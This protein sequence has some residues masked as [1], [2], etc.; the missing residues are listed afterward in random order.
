MDQSI[1]QSLVKWPNV[2]HCFGWLALDRRG[3]WRM[4]DDYAQVHGLSGDVIKHAAL[5][6]FIARNYASDAEGRYFFQN[7]PQRV[8]INLDATPWVIRMMPTGNAEH[9]WQFQTQCDS[10]LLPTAAFMDEAGHILIEG[11]LTQTICTVAT[12][13]QFSEIERLSI[14][15]L[16]DHDIELFSGLASLSN[17]VC[18]LEGIWRWHDHDLKLEPIA[19]TELESRFQFQTRPQP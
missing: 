14:A 8:Y 6:A 19:T 16:H 7:G 10:L 5:N 17:T 13:N 9:P 18:A 1:A 4:R 12:L 2:P 11:K 15:L 3:A